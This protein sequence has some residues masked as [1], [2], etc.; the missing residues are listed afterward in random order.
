M[1]YYLSTF[2]L[3]QLAFV[4]KFLECIA[5]ESKLLNVTWSCIKEDVNFR[6]HFRGTSLVVQWL[7]IHL[8]M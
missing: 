8:P 3:A 4:L 6:Y 1:H 2:M 7:R 5:I